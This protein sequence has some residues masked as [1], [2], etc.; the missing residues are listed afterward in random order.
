MPEWASLVIH[1]LWHSTGEIEYIQ[2]DAANRSRYSCT[3]SQV[4]HLAPD[5][6]DTGSQLVLSACARNGDLLLQT[7]AHRCVMYTFAMQ[8]TN[9][10]HHAT[11]TRCFTFESYEFGV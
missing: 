4:S 6:C 7:V 8:R 11:Q 10:L 2:L 1:G 3:S 9:P 5:S